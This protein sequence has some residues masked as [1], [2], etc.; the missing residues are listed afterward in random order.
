[1]LG[2]VCMACSIH[3]WHPQQEADLAPAEAQREGSSHSEAPSPGSHC[4][5]WPRP[6]PALSSAHALPLLLPPWK[7]PPCC[8]A[9]PAAA[10]LGPAAPKC[11]E[12][13]PCHACAVHISRWDGRQQRPLNPIEDQ[14]Q[15]MHKGHD[16]GMQAKLTQTGQAPLL[17]DEDGRCRGAG[18]C[19]WGERGAA[20]AGAAKTM[21]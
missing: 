14:K 10:S 12:L 21:L 18:E 13:V 16:A 11:A 15:G 17:L 8:L 4:Q 6:A 1:M 3:A 9:G 7:L 20:A 19:A 2:M 5:R